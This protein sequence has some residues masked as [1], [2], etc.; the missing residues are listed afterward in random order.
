MN[1]RYT[2]YFLLL[3]VSIIWGVAGPVI[4]FTLSSFPPI[5]FLT[6]RFALASALGATLWAIRP[7]QFRLKANTVPH[8]IAHSVLAVPL[9]LGLLF[10]GFDKTSSL[11]GSVI[12]ATGPIMV[13]IAGMLLLKEHI[14]KPERIGI[15]LALLGTLIITV[16]PMVGGN[17][18]A[19]I[20]IEGNLLIIVSLAADAIATVI[21]KVSLR[22]RVPAIVL[23]NISFMI[24][25]VCFLPFLLYTYS[26][27]EIVTTIASAPLSAHIGVLY[28]AFISGT[29]AYTLQ[30]LAMKSIEVGEVAVFN[31]LFP[32]WAA[33]LALWW[34]G[35][36]ITLPFVIGAAVIATG[37]VIAEYKRR[38]KR[39]QKRR[40]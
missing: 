20:S 19:L 27:Q 40:K 2:A 15:F 30:K 10:F 38:Q 14:T 17:G 21:A 23:T 8:I 36:K 31:Y 18:H 4:K 3:I 1:H 11:T 7:P 37:V 35:E 34:L 6:Y 28:M 12:S 16:G 24:G 9:G 25:F 29:L 13:A 33:P 39:R 32:I 22:D 26:I 5:I